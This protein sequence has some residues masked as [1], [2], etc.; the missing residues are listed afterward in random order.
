VDEK[1]RRSDRGG[2]IVEEEGSWRIDRGKEIE[3]NGL[4]RTDRG[5]VVIVEGRSWKRDRGRDR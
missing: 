2:E 4:R 1:L 5:V 3:E